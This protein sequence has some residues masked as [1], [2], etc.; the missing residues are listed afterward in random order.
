[1]LSKIAKKKEDGHST[2]VSNVSNTTVNNYFVVN[3]PAVPS[4]KVPDWIKQQAKL[5]P[6]SALPR[7]QLA[8]TSFPASAADVSQVLEVKNNKKTAMEVEDGEIWEDDQVYTD[9]DWEEWNNSVN[10]AEYLN[11]AFAKNLNEAANKH[12]ENV[13]AANK[14]YDAAN[15]QEN[16]KAAAAN[17]SNNDAQPDPS[18]SSSNNNN[19]HDPTTPAATPRC[20]FA[21]PGK[22]QKRGSGLFGTGAAGKPV[23][24]GERDAR[25][26][27]GKADNRARGVKVDGAGVYGRVRAKAKKVEDVSVIGV[28]FEREISLKATCCCCLGLVNF[29]LV[30]EDL[31]A[32]DG[33]TIHFFRPL[34]CN[35]VNNK[36]FESPKMFYRLDLL[37][38]PIR[39]SAG[40]KSLHTRG[41]CYEVEM[42]EG[43]T[44]FHTQQQRYHKSFCYFCKGTGNSNDFI[45]VEDFFQDLY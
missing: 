20:H 37:N 38:H 7:K 32:G 21:S 43:Y 28:K 29:D 36:Y 2:S 6:A 30:I 41:G 16:D 8:L 14:L 42:V 25:F 15:K 1:M 22:K 33:W 26:Q 3:I 39:A 31:M 12:H 24:S 18:S 9:K 5:V 34:H 19:N 23:N 44:A 10:D 40:V 45:I 11:E 4:M 35:F 17:G 13:K 27:Y